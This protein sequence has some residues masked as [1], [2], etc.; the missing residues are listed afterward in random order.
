MNEARINAIFNR[1][2]LV[3]TVLAVS[4]GLLLLSGRPIQVSY[5]LAYLTLVTFVV[6][7]VETF[8]EICLAALLFL[9]KAVANWFTA[10]DME[11]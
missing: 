9:P 3:I 6:T 11:D 7:F 8:S 10:R 4:Y 1:C 5:F 2:L